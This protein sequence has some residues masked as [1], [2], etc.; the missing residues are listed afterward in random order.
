MDRIRT[1]LIALSL[2]AI[3]GGAIDASAKKNDKKPALD[4]YCPVAY[5]FGHAVKGTPEF[6]SDYGGKTYQFPAAE[7]KQAFDKDPK[8]YADAVAYDGWCAT[9][10]AYGKRVAA[11]PTVFEVY[12]N[13]TFRFASQQA[14]DAFDQHRD[15]LIAKADANWPR[16]SH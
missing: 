6:T 3:V 12:Q 15:D 16:L 5:K 8:T 14:K 9:A 11:D 7:A 10:V 2:I 1:P 13:R 4:G